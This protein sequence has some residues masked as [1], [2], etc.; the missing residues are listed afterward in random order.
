[1][2]WQNGSVP[3]KKKKS[4]FSTFV[5]LNEVKNLLFERVTQMMEETLKW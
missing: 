3:S 4:I 2:A 1:M 5:P